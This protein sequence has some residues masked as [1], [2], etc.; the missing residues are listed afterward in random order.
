[1]YKKICESGVEETIDIM[2]EGRRLKIKLP[3]E[4]HRCMYL[5][6]PFLS[7]IFYRYVVDNRS[8]HCLLTRFLDFKPQ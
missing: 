2:I 7:T 8:T 6:R 1:M 3:M 5:S 4:D